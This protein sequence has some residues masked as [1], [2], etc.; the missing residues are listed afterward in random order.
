[1]SKQSD[2]KVLRY[3]YNWYKRQSYVTLLFKVR[4]ATIAETDKMVLALQKFK[5]C[6]VETINAGVPNQEGNVMQSLLSVSFL[7]PLTALP[8]EFY[9][10]LHS[11]YLNS[12]L[13]FLIRYC[14]ENDIT[15]SYTMDVEAYSQ[16]IAHELPFIFNLP[17]VPT[18]K[19]AGGHLEL[20]VSQFMKLYKKWCLDRATTLLGGCS[21]E[22][23][24]ENVKDSPI[25]REEKY[26]ELADSHEEER[27]CYACFA[28]KLSNW[29]LDEIN[30]WLK[31]MATVE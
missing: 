13:G 29:C 15:V 18:L 7:V 5:Q 21:S 11:Q 23:K 25:F 24:L 4:N 16:F 2:E 12:I 27:Y 31:S 17:S 22:E 30:N 8:F 9:K 14:E 26:K 6:H 28:E 19:N 10:T 1:M 20:T 3:M